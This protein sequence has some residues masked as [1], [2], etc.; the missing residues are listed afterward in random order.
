[1]NTLIQSLQNQTLYTHAVSGFQII[2]THL[3]WVILTGSFAY[4]IKKPLNLGFQDFTT[5][6][7]RKKYCELEVELNKR[8][9]PQL[10]I[11]T[12]AI[13]GSP[14]DPHFNGEGEVIEYAVKMHQ[15][16]Q[17]NLLSHLVVKKQ[18]TKEIIDNI[19]YQTAAFHQKAALC[20]HDI[21]FG[22]PEIVYEP[23]VD[24]FTALASLTASSHYVK[25]IEL[26]KNWTHAKYQQLSP[27]LA[28]RKKH[29][30]IRATHGDFHLGNMVMW[31]NQPLIFDCIEFNESFR[32]TDVMNDVSFLAMDLDH[33]HQSALS[34]AFVNTYLE[35]SC[36]YQ[37][38]MLLAFYKCYRAMV[39]A[40]ISAIQL[41]QVN[42][43]TE[44][45]QQLLKNLDAFMKL[46]LRYASGEKP[47]LTI[48]YGL[49]GS[50]KSL[51]SEH[52]ALQAGAIRVR[53]DIIRKNLF[54]LN[55]SELYTKE[56][57]LKVYSKLLEIAKELISAELGVVVDATFLKAAQ[58]QSFITLAST[59]N[60]PI[61]ILCF[62]APVDV[63]KKR[64]MARAI[65]QKD[66]SDADS[67]VLNLQ[68]TAI[69]PLTEQE[70][71][72]ATFIPAAEIEQLI[73]NR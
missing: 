45:Y 64:I 46:G 72:I 58:R 71:A 1:M 9:A 17:D 56:T 63:L 43:Q 16:P 37:G 36:D 20:P 41:D 52:F 67:E 13:T 39:R 59:L 29:G 31:E 33:H 44:L 49:S 11:G 12:V 14:A 5:L 19:A 57:S 30:F 69:E 25:E 60:V 15:F 22:N 34:N 66:P 24:N 68:L 8:L 61:K 7:K 54:G 6:E 23:M 48:T 47:N 62:D 50:G 65:T 51:Y 55:T 32:F 4:K 2:E 35:Q 28:S 27:L 10:Y 26:I 53:S 70:K 73:E 21:N 18:L 3:S 38:A 40:K 42:P